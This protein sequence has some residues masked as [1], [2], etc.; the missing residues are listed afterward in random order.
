[1]VRGVVSQ[2]GGDKVAGASLMECRWKVNE[3]CYI[4]DP[5]DLFEFIDYESGFSSPFRL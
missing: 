1:M 4:L 3:E 2:P 5:H